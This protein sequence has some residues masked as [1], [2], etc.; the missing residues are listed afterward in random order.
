M[1]YRQYISHVIAAA[2]PRFD[3]K[4]AERRSW[5]RG[6]LDH[7]ERHRAEIDARDAGRDWWLTGDDRWHKAA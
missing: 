1:T 4:D 7:Y 3:G 2:A 6:H 5:M